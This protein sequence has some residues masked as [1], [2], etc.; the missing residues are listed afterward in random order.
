MAALDDG[1]RRYLKDMIAAFGGEDAVEGD[2]V[3]AAYDAIRHWR[4]GLPESA[5]MTRSPG[6]DG[7]AFQEAIRSFGD[8]FDLLMRDFPRM[9]GRERPGPEIV[10]RIIELRRR[11]EGV[12]A[13]RATQSGCRGRAPP[14]W[15]APPGR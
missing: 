12:V 1:V 4:A 7:R 11:L 6:D 14:A 13:R 15:A 3:R 8:P 10:P 9:A 2:L 5:L